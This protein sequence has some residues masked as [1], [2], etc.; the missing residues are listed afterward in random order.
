M[1]LW[2]VD[3]RP[4]FSKGGYCNRSD[5]NATFTFVCRALHDSP[6]ALFT[7]TYL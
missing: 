1:D 7:P 4:V 6:L 3:R 5:L 2:L